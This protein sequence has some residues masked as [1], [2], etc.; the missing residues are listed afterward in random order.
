MP[1]IPSF[2]RRARTE[3]ILAGIELGLELKFGTEGLQMMAEVRRITDVEALQGIRQAI[4]T[5][6]TV[7]D[8]RQIVAAKS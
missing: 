4:K 3:E 8:F 7:D 2:E 6:A 1:F 5:A